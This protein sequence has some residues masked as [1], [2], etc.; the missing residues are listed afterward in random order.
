MVLRKTEDSCLRQPDVIDSHKKFLAQVR[1]RYMFVPCS[2]DGT[3]LDEPIN[4]RV[5]KNLYEE[6]PNCII[7][8]KEHEAY[9]KA[10]KRVL[11]EGFFHEEGNIRC[12]YDFQGIEFDGV[13]NIESLIE[14][15]SLLLTDQAKKI[16]GIGN[17]EDKLL[18]MIDF[19]LREEGDNLKFAKFSNQILTKGMFL[20]CRGNI[21]LEDPGLVPSQEQRDYREAKDKIL[22]KVINSKGEDM[23]PKK[24]S[25]YFDS[26]LYN[27]TVGDMA[28]IGFN[29]LLTE[30]AKREIGI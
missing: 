22:F 14:Y 11:F 8:F 12:K 5:F 27:L 25:A 19:V 21:V 20:P 28:L 6:D 29:V 15:Y 3:M 16:L 9:Y 30:T 10:E 1:E 23:D 26:G 4:Y 2:E 17:Y 7:G 13:K 18:T 24:L